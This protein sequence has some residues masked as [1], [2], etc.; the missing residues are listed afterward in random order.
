MESKYVYLFV[1]ILFSI[2]NLVIFLLGRQLRKGKM[3]Y[4]VSGY[5]PKKHDKERMGKYAGNSMIFTS[6]FMFI[7]V[8]LPLVGKMIYEENTLY[9]VIIKVSFVLFFI[10]VIIRAILVGK[11]VNK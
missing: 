7:G 3:V 6:V 11:Y 10:I 4:I 9:G 5:D 2:I 8:V 1:I